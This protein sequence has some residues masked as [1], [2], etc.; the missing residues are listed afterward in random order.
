MR[1][2][3]IPQKRFNFAKLADEAVKDKEEMFNS[4]ISLDASSNKIDLSVSS[5]LSPQP[6]PAAITSGVALLTSNTT[7]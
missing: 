2:S 6:A 1:K 7:L 3:N 5:T 4:S